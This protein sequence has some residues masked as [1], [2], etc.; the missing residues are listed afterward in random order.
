M[1]VDRLIL[2]L[3]QLHLDLFILAKCSV[4][5]Q[6]LGYLVSRDKFLFES[7][8]VNTQQMLGHCV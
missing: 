7:E 3:F 5:A 4:C 6:C 1:L 8:P 2:P